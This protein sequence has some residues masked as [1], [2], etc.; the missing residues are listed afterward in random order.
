MAKLFNCTT[1]EFAHKILKANTDE[2]LSMLREFYSTKNVPE[3]LLNE[4]FPI[5]E[6]SPTSNNVDSERKFSPFRKVVDRSK[7]NL[8][9]QEKVV[10][11][12]EN[13]F[14]S[15]PSASR[16]NCSPSPS[17]VDDSLRIAVLDDLVDLRFTK[18]KPYPAPSTKSKQIVEGNDRSK[19]STV[20]ESIPLLD[21]LLKF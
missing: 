13:L 18:I 17:V 8:I 5:G 3:I 14:S 1:T 2:R 4:I 7:R 10:D 6:T 12:L 15:K 19:V 9:E 11:P 21:D 16:L 20:V